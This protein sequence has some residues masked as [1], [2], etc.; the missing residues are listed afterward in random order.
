MVDGTISHERNDILE[1]WRFKNSKLFESQI[2]EVDDNFIDNFERLNSEMERKLKNLDLNESDSD[3]TNNEMNDV[4]GIEE[5]RNAMNALKQ[6][7]AV[8]VDNL[9][10]E[11]LKNE[12]L[13]NIFNQLF[14]LCFIHG[15]LPN[16]WYKSIICPIL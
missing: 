3:V 15:T 7:K 12:N 14:N 11:I 1:Q 5:T 9:P 4:I 8:G 6:G 10:N 2:M 13:V 16:V